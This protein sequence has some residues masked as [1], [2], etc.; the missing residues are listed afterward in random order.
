MKMGKYV[1]DANDINSVFLVSYLGEMCM[2]YCVSSALV[3][4]TDI[5]KKR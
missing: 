5:W 1:C 4:M 3:H 2:Q